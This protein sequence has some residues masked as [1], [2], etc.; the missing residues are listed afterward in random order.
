MTSPAEQMNKVPPLSRMGLKVITNTTN[1]LKIEMPLEGNN[2][3]IGVTYAGSMFT[4]AEFPFGM[5]FLNRFDENDIYPLV[6][7]MSIRYLAP[8]TG[9]LTVEVNMTD[10]EWDEIERVTRENGK[11]K[12]PRELEIKDLEG[13]VMA[14]VKATYFALLAEK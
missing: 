8:S 9:A 12:I 13:N 5:L 6:G 11:M 7:E 10:E 1:C 2:N 3:H 14:V 4:L